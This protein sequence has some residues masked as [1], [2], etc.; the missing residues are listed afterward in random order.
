[1]A[2]MPSAHDPTALHA[3]RVLDITQVMAGPF[4]STMLADLGADVIK[5]ESPAGDST[6][7]MS[8]AVGTDSPAFNAVNRGKRSLVV[9][10]KTDAGRS[11]LRRLAETA[12]I[13]VENY[14]PGVMA[15]FGLDYPTLSAANPRLIYASISGYGQT[16]PDRLKGGLDLIAQG[17][18]GLMSITGE[19]G[20][21]PVK[22][23]IPVTDLGAGLFA[24]V[25][26]LAALEA[27]HQT[28]LGQHV[29][30]SL[31]EAG[32]A[33]S[34]WEATEYFTEGRS[35]QPTGSAHRLHAPYQA[36]RCADGYITIGAATDR[37][38]PK[39]CAVLGHPE[40]TSIPEFATT[41]SRVRHRAALADTIEA[42]TAGRPR[43]HWLQQLE[44]A[45]VPCGPLNDYAQVFADPQIVAR[46]MVVDVEHP[47]LGTLRALG[48]PIKL[49]A[50]PADARRRAPLLGE[51]TKDILTEA[52]FSTEE[53]AALRAARAIG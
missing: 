32:V 7:Q 37:L 44:A 39:L 48:S 13:L 12:D 8:S 21:A 22:T 30:T 49:S 26:I 6:R 9:D 40:W 24:L 3:L 11:V 1:M 50:T 15:T 10:L 35:P 41:P 4:C 19:P 17:V 38:F 36:F 47:T 5:I 43:A 31:V 25:G 34:V 14:R 29:D 23:G 46:E 28:G 53:I 27:R 42:V 20:G 51:H 52:G 45:G 33:L 16:G 18:S 2:A